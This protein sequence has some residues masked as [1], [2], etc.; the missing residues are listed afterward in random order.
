MKHTLFNRLRC[1]VAGCAFVFMSNIAQANE[2]VVD[3]ELILAVDISQSMDPE[4]QRVQREGYISALTSQEFLDAVSYG[5]N[6]KIAVLYLEWGGD[7]EQFIIA[8]WQV[9]SD[10]KSAEMFA[11]RIAEQP[12][13]KVQRTS[14][15]SVI[16][17]SKKLFAQNQYQGLRQVL[18]ISGDGPNNQGRAVLQA[19]D[20]AIRDGIVINGLPL[21]LKEENLSWQSMLNL[22]HY[23]QD[24]VIGGAGAFSI[25]VRSIEHF[26]DAIRLKMILEI[27]G[28]T[29]VNPKLLPAKQ[30]KKVNCSIFN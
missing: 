29:S 11:A 17:F 9:I 26:S 15:S 7:G 19:R 23:F 4:E 16:D 30:R 18:D 1:I 24:C 22:D 6:G 3:V 10:M 2:H 20:E 13:R 5:A 27:A 21:M 14:I 25:P 28:V 12:L 8:D